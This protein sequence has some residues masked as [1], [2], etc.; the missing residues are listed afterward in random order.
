MVFTSSDKLAGEIA[1]GVINTYPRSCAHVFNHIGWDEG[2]L[3]SDNSGTLKTF[4]KNLPPVNRKKEKC[5]SLKL[6]KVE[7]RKAINLV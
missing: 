6:F 5:Y 7:R 1:A 4:S 3:F 2:F